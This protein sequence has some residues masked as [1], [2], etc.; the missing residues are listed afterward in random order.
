MTRNQMRKKLQLILTHNLMMANN[1][2][3]NEQDKYAVSHPQMYRLYK[4]IAYLAK[5][6]STLEKSIARPG[7]EIE[8]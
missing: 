8:E 3:K 6:I 4:D 7:E 2:S 5:T 1:H